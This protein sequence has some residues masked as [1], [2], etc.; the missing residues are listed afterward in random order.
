MAYTQTQTIADTDRRHVLKRINYAN[1]ETSALVVN[2]S[3]LNFA[4][5]T[6][7]TDASANNFKVG[8]TIN[9]SS[10][11]SATVQ[12]VA[13][14][15]SI[16]VI[17]LTGTFADNDTLTGATTGRIRTQYNSVANAVYVLEVANISY[18]VGGPTGQEKVELMWEGLGGGANNRTIAIVSGTGQLDLAAMNMRANNNAVN[19]TGNIILS[20]LHWGAN[21]H[22]T[23]L[24]DVSKQAGYKTP[25]TERNVLGRF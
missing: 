18:D 17:G 24:A 5:V 9:S 13:N 20:T 22:Y 2:A 1:T 3:A 25:N 4:V 23:L 19:A 16:T 15:T 14:D 11:G 6:I 12:D 10:G 8:E 7:T 21:A